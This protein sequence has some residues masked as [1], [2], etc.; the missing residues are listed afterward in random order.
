[1]RTPDD[2]QEALPA[3][4]R[5]GLA[6]LKQDNQPLPLAVEQRLQQARQAAVAR[7]KSPA[8]GVSLQGWTLALVGHPRAAGMLALSLFLMVG[9]VYFSPA[10]N[11]D[12]LLLSDDMPVEAF[13]DNAFDAWKYSENI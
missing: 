8:S 6:D 13:V 11:D 4:L 10:H 12:A 2:Q 7:I 5:Q 3:A 1:M 9:M